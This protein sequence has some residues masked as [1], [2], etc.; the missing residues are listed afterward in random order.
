MDPINEDLAKSVEAEEQFLRDLT[1]RSDAGED[2]SQELERGNDSPAIA[3]GDKPASDDKSEEKQEQSQKG[4]EE[5]SKDK[6][7][8]LN[9]KTDTSGKESAANKKPEEAKV[10]ETKFQRAK[11]DADRLDRSWKSLNEQKEAVR[12]EKES[13]LAKEKA[14]DDRIKSLEKKLAET[15][16]KPSTAEPKAE[17]YEQAAKDYREDAERLERRGDTEAADKLLQKARACERFANQKRQEARETEENQKKISSQAEVEKFT[18]EWDEN[19]EKLKKSDEFKELEN[20]DSPMGLE[21]RRLLRDNPVLSTYSGGIKD[22]A[23][24]AKLQMAA[25]SLPGVQAKLAEV[26]KKY[27]E[28][29]S[30]MRIGPSGEPE[31]PK[32]KVYGENMTLEEEE[33]FLLQQAAMSDGR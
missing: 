4:S 15:Q 28:L 5:Q 10:E 29:Q 18:K 13:M 31:P 12:L 25:N 21:V 20:P 14:W 23:H 19:L 6:T 2:I 11:K 1:R 3:S 22:A 16:A 32:Q 27:A 7:D 33:A 17:D 26:E 9:S 8:K 30:R 24:I